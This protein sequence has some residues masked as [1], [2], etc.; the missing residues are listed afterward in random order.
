MA[1][2]FSAAT[3]SGENADASSSW[4]IVIPTINGPQDQ[5]R[6]RFSAG[7]TTGGIAQA[8]H[9]SIGVYTSGNSNT[10]A[11]PIELLFG[12]ASGF[13]F[14]KPASVP[15]FIWSD[16]TTF[17]GWTSGNNLVVVIDMGAAATSFC[18][19]TPVDAALQNWVYSAL[20]SYNSATEPGTPAAGS[21]F[22]LETWGADIIE[23]RTTPVLLKPKSLAPVKRTLVNRL[24]AY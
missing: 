17:N 20:A 18:R 21:P 4:R 6:V 19:A 9:C 10:V 22:T 23:V 13:Q 3:V 8:D 2:A 12:G 1:I 24:K 5:V 7:T 15:S 11:T 16:W 14:T